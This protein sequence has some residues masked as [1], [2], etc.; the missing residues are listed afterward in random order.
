MSASEF[1]RCPSC[2]APHAPEEAFC[3]MCHRPFWNDPAKKTPAA[4][5]APA[6][7]PVPKTAPAPAPSA[8]IFND[9]WTQSV[10]IVAFILIITGLAQGSGTGTLI[11]WFGLIPAFF[12]TA[13]AGFRAPKTEP[14]T[15]L[16][17]IERFVTKGA[18]IV[19][20]MILVIIA[21]ILALMAACA[22]IISLMH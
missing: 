1:D 18:S 5:S 16:E 9:G 10:M 13:L 4:A 21:I 15:A 22:A 14:T 7:V 2:Q 19:A 8:S 6:P 20:M 17:K 3:W 11:M 12:V